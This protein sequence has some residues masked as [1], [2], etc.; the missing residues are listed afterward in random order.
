MPHC[1][2]EEA[3]TRML[4]HMKHMIENGLKT[5]SLKTVD[6]DV[7][8][9]LVGLFYKIADQV[10]DIWVEYGAGKH[11]QYISIRTMQNQLGVLKAKAILFFH[12]FTGSD[13]TSAF[14]NKGK[15]TAWNTWK[16]FEE[17]TETFA[18][19]SVEPFK[20]IDNDSK[21]VETLERFVIYM[22]IVIIFKEGE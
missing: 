4:F 6:S 2:Q 11:L 7:V 8:V 17:V 18:N 13:T 16:A 9:I 20:P 12:A 22:Y 3:D 10:D 5:I 19:L 15:K 14:R 21:E 1:F